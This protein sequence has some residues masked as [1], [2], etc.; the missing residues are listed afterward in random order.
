V[1][2]SGKLFEKNYLAFR[3]YLKL[4]HVEIG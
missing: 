3:A 2:V 1:Q 4:G